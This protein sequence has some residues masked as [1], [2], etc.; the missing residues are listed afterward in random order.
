MCIFLAHIDWI[1][2]ATHD[3]KKIKGNLKVK[4]W[5]ANSEI[6]NCSSTVIDPMR[7]GTASAFFTCHLFYPQ[8]QEHSV[9]HS[10][11][12]INIC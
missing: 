5:N 12:L 9:V 11:H 6:W 10:S 4:K 1:I 2:K 3:P 8:L 7:T